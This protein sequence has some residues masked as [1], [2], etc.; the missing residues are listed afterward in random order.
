M[1]R[2]DPTNDERTFLKEVLIPTREG[3]MAKGRRGGKHHPGDEEKGKG[4]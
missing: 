3:E 2:T 4:K 1:S